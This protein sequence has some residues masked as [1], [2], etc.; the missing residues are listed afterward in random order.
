MS[1]QHIAPTLALIALILLWFSLI[2]AEV[3]RNYYIIEVDKTKPNYLQSFILRGFIALIHAILFNPQNI[4][5]WLPILVF[6]LSSFFVIFSPLLNKLRNEEFFYLGKESGFI[7]PFLLRYPALHRIL[8]FLSA[9]LII[10]SAILIIRIY[11]GGVEG[12]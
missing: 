9:L 5:E 7:D 8:Y 4:I 11:G 3:L 1:F 12:T 10:V 2:P 6:Q